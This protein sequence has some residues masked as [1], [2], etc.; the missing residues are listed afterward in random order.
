M[1]YNDI[2]RELKDF[3]LKR[4]YGKAEIKGGQ[5]HYYDS[6]FDRL[7][8]ASDITIFEKEYSLTN[9]VEEAVK[10]LSI[11]DLENL[12]EEKKDFIETIEPFGY[13]NI[14]EE[15]LKDFCYKLEVI[16]GKLNDI[17][18]KRSFS[19]SDDKT[20][21]TLSKKIA[22][23]HE[24]GFYTLSD[25]NNENENF[26]AKITRLIVGGS[27]DTL[28]RHLNNFNTDIEHIDPKYGAYNHSDSSRLLIE[29]TR[30]R[31]GKK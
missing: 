26:K 4:K 1:K 27:V 23:L 13:M 22:L 19:N 5:E 21:L 15:K 3:E 6:I 14:S 9:D 28:R 31:P 17:L 20:Q 29:N 18:E 7:T 10:D 8:N 11:E 30:E 24:L 16:V 2:K 25:F 12:I